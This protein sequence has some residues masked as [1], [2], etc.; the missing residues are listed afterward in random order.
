MR[1]TQK[2]ID[3]STWG[4]T[5]HVPMPRLPANCTKCWFCGKPRPPLMEGQKLPDPLK[6]S[7]PI[8]PL[9]KKAKPSFVAVAETS[10]VRPKCA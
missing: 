9:P 1:Y 10:K 3:S 8:R 2:W 4:C 5:S 7:E 6:K